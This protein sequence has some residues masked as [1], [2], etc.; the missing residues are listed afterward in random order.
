MQ[1]SNRPAQYTS[2]QLL[3]SRNWVC[4][5]LPP[6]PSNPLSY[7][8]SCFPLAQKPSDSTRRDHTVPLRPNGESDHRPALNCTTRLG[9]MTTPRLQVPL[10]W[11]VQRG[12]APCTSPSAHLH[13]L[14]VTKSRLSAVSGH[15]L[16]RIPAQRRASLGTC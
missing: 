12:I 5:F 1:R 15:P 16:I 11:A 13:R 7:T 6:I 4:H 3:S 9:E 2:M 10:H 14:K 8:R